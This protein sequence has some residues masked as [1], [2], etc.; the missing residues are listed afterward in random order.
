MQRSEK[1][2][3]LEEAVIF[4]IQ[5]SLQTCFKEDF[6]VYDFGKIS[7]GELSSRPFCNTYS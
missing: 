6:N 7:H 5:L 3:P 2:I 1:M 4:S